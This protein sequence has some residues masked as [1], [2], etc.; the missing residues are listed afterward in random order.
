[1]ET[2]LQLPLIMFILDNRDTD[3]VTDEFF[4]QFKVL[5]LIL[6][7]PVFDVVIFPFSFLLL[8]LASK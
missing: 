5:L 2:I 8:G 6:S 3:A 1:M 7:S 4:D